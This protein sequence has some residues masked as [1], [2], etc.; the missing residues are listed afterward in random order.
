MVHNFTPAT[1]LVT[2]AAFPVFVKDEAT[3]ESKF[4]PHPSQKIVI[5]SSAELLDYHVK[6]SKF[7]SRAD[8]CLVHDLKGQPVV[9]SIGTTKHVHLFCYVDGGS[10]SWQAFDINPGDDF[11]AQ[12]VNVG[13]NSSGSKILFATSGKSKATGNT[14][15]YRAFLDSPDLKVGKDGTVNNETIRRLEWVEIGGELANRQ[16]K[17]LNCSYFDN[18]KYQIVAGV[19]ATAIVEGSNYIYSGT[20]GQ[21]AWAIVKSPQQTEKVRSCVPGNLN[22]L[23]EGHF[24]LSEDATKEGFVSCVFRGKTSKQ[25]FLTGLKN[26]RKLSININT[27][28]LSDLL[29]A[30][31]NGIGFVNQYQS[32]YKPQILLEDISFS[33][34]VCFEKKVSDEMSSLM[35]FGLSTYGELFTIEGTRMAADKSNVQFKT[36]GLP[37]RQNVQNIAGRINKVTGVCEV[38]WIGRSEDSIRHLIKDPVTSMWN[39]SEIIVQ[40]SKAIQKTKIN[41]YVMN[42]SLTNGKG[43]P[44]PLDYQVQLTSTPSLV[45][46][47]DCTY[48]LGRRPQT[49][50]LNQR[51]QLQIAIPIPDSSTL[52]VSP[53][54]IRFLPE[55]GEA[56]EFPVQ[57]SQRILHVFKNLNTAESLRDARGQD[58]R[59]LFSNEQKTKHKD[60]FGQLAEVLS[61]APSLAGSND[62]E[63]AKV[64][65]ASAADDYTINW[66]DKDDED[67]WT[68]RAVDVVGGF[69][70][71]AVEFLKTCVK[72]VAKIALEIVGS[73][74][75]FVLK[76]GAKVI[77]FV[78]DT[79]SAIVSGLC[80]ALEWLTGKDF[81]WLRDFFTFR[82]QKVEATQ[83]E[84]SILVDRG[85]ELTS[86]FLH[87]NRDSLVNGF[88]TI[89]DYLKELIDRP[90]DDEE[91]E[92]APADDGYSIFNNP[93]IAN[94]LK[95]NPLQWIMEAATEEF[96]NDF[97][98]PVLDLGIGKNIIGA[99]KEQFK[100]LSDLLS[101]NWTSFESCMSEPRNIMKHLKDIMR[102]TFWALFDAIKAII[103]RIYDMVMNAFDGITAF[104]RGKW[105]IP[106][107][108]DLWKD[109]TGLDF[110]LINFVTY[111]G[112]Q[113]LECF[114]PSETPVFD[115]FKP[116]RVLQEPSKMGIPKLLPPK[117]VANYDSYKNSDASFEEQIM[118]QSK[119]QEE[120]M[121][122]M[123]ANPVTTP[124]FG[125]MA[126]TASVPE[127]LP[128]RDDHPEHR[129]LE[130]T[131]TERYIVALC[132][133]GKNLGRTVNVAVQGFSAPDTSGSGGG[134]GG[135]GGGEIEL[136]PLNK[137]AEDAIS[138]LAQ[139][140]PS[141]VD[142]GTIMKGGSPVVGVKA[143][144][145]G[146]NS[147]ALT[148]KIVEQVV[149]L[150][151]YEETARHAEGFDGNCVDIITSLVGLVLTCVSSNP[152]VLAIANLLN[153]VGNFAGTM[154]KPD[155]G[156]WDVCNLV[157]ASCSCVSSILFLVPEPDCKT[158]AWVGVGI[159][160]V[161]TLMTIGKQ[162][163]DAGQDHPQPHKPPVE[164]PPGPVPQPP[165]PG[166]K[167][168]PEPT[169]QTPGPVDP[170]PK[171]TIPDLKF[172]ETLYEHMKQLIWNANAMYEK[173]LRE[174]AEAQGKQPFLNYPTPKE[175][176]KELFTDNIANG[177][178]INKWIATIREYLLKRLIE[179]GQSVSPSGGQSQ[180][181][182]VL[183][184]LKGL[185][186]RLCS[187]QGNIPDNLLFAPFLIVLG[188][189][190]VTEAASTVIGALFSFI[191]YLV[192]GGDPQK[193]P[194]APTI[195]PPIVI[196]WPPRTRNPTR[197]GSPPPPPP[198][199]PSPQPT[200]RIPRR[201]SR[202]PKRRRRGRD[203][204]KR[205]SRKDYYF[206][207]VDRIEKLEHGFEIRIEAIAES[208]FGDEIFLGTLQKL[209]VAGGVPL[210]LA[211]FRLALVHL[212]VHTVPAGVTEG[213]W[214]NFKVDTKE[215][216]QATYTTPSVNSNFKDGLTVLEPLQPR[217]NFELFCIDSFFETEYGYI[218][219]TDMKTV[220][221]EILPT[222]LTVLKVALG[223][224]NSIAESI[225][226]QIE[227]LIQS[228]DSDA[229]TKADELSTGE[230]E[231]TLKKALTG[232]PMVTPAAIKP[233]PKL[234]PGIA[235]GGQIGR[236]L[237][238]RYNASKYCIYQV[239][240]GHAA[241][242]YDEDDEV[243]F[244]NDF[245]YGKL[246]ANSVEIVANHMLKQD[247]TPILLSHWDADH[248]R[249][250]LS[251][252]AKGYA[253]TK[254]HSYLRSWIAPGSS[255][256]IGSIANELA[257]GVQSKGNLVQW[258]DSVAE[259]KAGNMKIIR[260][261]R[262]K[263]FNLPD[264]NNLGALALLIGSG[265]QKLLYPGDANF[266]SIP[267][268]E[269]LS[270]KLRTV[271][272]THHGS[273][274]SLR[275]HGQM[276]EN[277][278]TSSP[279][280]SHAIFSY[281]KG[282]SFGHNISKAYPAYENKGYQVADGT[283]LFKD[284][285]DT[286]EIFHFGGGS[287]FASSKFMAARSL[288]V[289]ESTEE[290]HS[291]AVIEEGPEIEE[292]VKVTGPNITNPSDLPNYMKMSSIPKPEPHVAANLPPAI[293]K[294]GYKK[295]FP[296]VITLTGGGKGSSVDDLIKY[297]HR[298]TDGDI[299]F[300]EIIAKK[301][302]LEKLPLYVPCHS[303]YPV[304]V[305]ITCQDIEI[306]VNNPQQTV[307][308][309]VHFA[310]ADGE[311]WSGDADHGQDGKEGE[312]GYAGGGLRVMVSGNWT[313]SPSAPISQLVV[314]Y[315]G[316]SGGNGQNGGQGQASKD[317][318]AGGRGGDVGP[319]GTMAES[320]IITLK[321]N[322]PAGWET[323][324]D[325]E[326][327][328]KQGQAG[329][330]GKGG[331]LPYGTT[332][333]DGENGLPAEVPEM[334]QFSVVE[335]E[336]EEELLGVMAWVDWRH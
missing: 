170:P 310:V 218:V 272:A 182:A 318:G 44:V 195:I 55:S 179:H 201:R 197:P 188:C 109:I 116:S 103:L 231:K 152:V 56:N 161:N 323:T 126:T 277:I 330:G 223:S 279:L 326:R 305:Q 84:L 180:A 260:C 176:P 106:W 77:R 171:P 303:D 278:P 143:L 69:I 138:N 98:I 113:L 21:K 17:A 265:E 160:A 128:P 225:N 325:A 261:M 129:I 82:Y 258:T 213:D 15:I 200:P 139:L 168:K 124:R 105:E 298:N 30:S 8:I 38:I 4:Q 23:G 112:A 22:G 45:Y 26:P 169:D 307:V 264:K 192:G 156:G 140:E 83:K 238:L 240:Q 285:Q 165:K 293:L 335:L 301:V 254:F 306:C 29:V 70:G 196:P 237:N 111:V 99:L 144:T 89:R 137:Q 283:P 93:I 51:G 79:A 62:L 154:M 242:V 42:I 167:K 262:N 217:V 300:Y 199:G 86:L 253:H 328:G 66:Q 90:D 13:Q 241:H 164:E 259:Y 296:D 319:V 132:R 178:D 2:K 34:A 147:F 3:G 61:R 6:G 120:G 50:S 263:Q 114:N 211:R 309:L 41:A 16:V 43:A 315:T 85:L 220:T 234:K 101:K 206:G 332:G 141:G 75:R 10:S 142:A 18:T 60:N 333:P 314:Q 135:G 1:R 282:N 313:V 125:L 52:G 280:R 163:Y 78:L 157:G 227:N 336:T 215:K 235:T 32:I 110:T 229:E 327:F 239:G 63:P 150:N 7:E 212:Y 194:F 72:T 329:K 290:V 74:I 246:P 302:V 255:H 175:I 136:M 219:K 191:I 133:S 270:G 118:A 256:I 226:R 119:A 243:I 27:R 107:M 49:F 245:G 322:W 208:A 248:Y 57:P 64:T 230:T 134:G 209:F 267:N 35:I 130:A 121:R 58:G 233:K 145:I 11:E 31:D 222:I 71:D 108:T 189:V 131:K 202:S 275:G 46:V 181:D 247:E 183:Q 284:G 257:W 25:V 115:L 281:A 97:N 291:S 287:T 312:A 187:L 207:F 205:R 216:T 151:C 321:K 37:I 47:N 311:S 251:G 162:F 146:I 12:V 123:A 19:D 54:C 210:G 92:E 299:V 324:I 252:T 40:A 80:S 127:V 288:A 186:N 39:E 28:G 68:T 266:E 102:N 268:V 236:A 304:F 334:S 317:G 295:Q 24:I 198:P 308:P 214:I 331:Q 91:L 88:D 203:E 250:A 53:V 149:L 95:F 190:V 185:H 193:S 172:A 73:A 166:P 67:N 153:S 294:P 100:I 249:I 271:I 276:G 104:C 14:Q 158:I 76:I 117:W 20:G 221:K 174:I 204:S 59:A 274:R 316:G 286:L 269:K 5:Q 148:C 184:C 228:D 289:V 292:P 320:K 33:N 159:D 122:Y 48:N 94:L 173:S 36:S 65:P 96:G 9:V 87:N 297:A 155:I 81:S 244:A 224:F 273:T 177:G 232:V